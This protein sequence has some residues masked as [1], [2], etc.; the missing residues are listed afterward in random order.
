MAKPI[1]LKTKLDFTI[2]GNASRSPH[3]TIKRKIGAYNHVHI[4][5]NCGTVRALKDGK[6]WD[7]CR[8]E[9]NTDWIVFPAK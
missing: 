3:N 4:G 8:N 7:W 9:S 1:E 5:E 2:H 6:H